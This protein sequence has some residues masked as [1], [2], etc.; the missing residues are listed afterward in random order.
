M[1]A[2]FTKGQTIYKVNL[3]PS[4]R[5]VTEKIVKSCGLKR[6][7]L[8]LDHWNNSFRLPSITGNFKNPIKQFHAT[9]EDAE[10]ELLKH[11]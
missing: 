5:G 8:D 6:L 1:K 9:R 7:V 4:E 10:K 3:N 11:K 2:E